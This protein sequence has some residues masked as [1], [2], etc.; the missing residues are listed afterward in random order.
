MTA[1]PIPTTPAPA[2][3]SFMSYAR[4]RTRVELQTFMRNPQ[5]MFFTFSLPVM[6]LILFSAVFGNENLGGP[7]DK[8][9]VK[10]AQYFLPGII[11]SGIMS[12]TFLNVASAVSLSQHEGLL[13]RLSGTP[14]PRSAYFT[15]KLVAAAVITVI[16]TALML[17]VGILAYDS[18]LPADAGRWAAFGVMLLAGAGTGCLLGL[19]YTRLIPWLQ[20]A[21]SIFPLR[22]IAEGLR[23]AFLPDWFGESEYGTATWGWQWPT[24][25]LLGW[26]VL[27]FILARMFFKWDRTQ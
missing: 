20:A 11:A 2:L 15:G 3:P 8:T 22:W 26:L 23:Y 5:Q 7:V 13:K 16:Q 25:V 1:I 10:F 14:L 12:T 9:Q 18:K 24:I 4:S 17:G 6:L 21:A 27:A 19:A